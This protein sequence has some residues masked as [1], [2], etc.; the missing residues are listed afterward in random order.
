MMRRE[1]P[2]ALDFKP[3]TLAHKQLVDEYMFKYGENSCQHSFA[4]MFCYKGKY[5][6]SVREANGCLFVCREN[7]CCEKY[8]VYLM[9]MGGS[10]LA[11]AI[12]ALLDD[13]HSRGKLVKLETVTG[14]AKS[15]LE[16]YCPGMF[17]ASEQR[18]SAEY[19][20]TAEKL[21]NLPGKEMASKR[22]DV[23]TFW[24]SYSSRAAIKEM[25]AD[26][27]EEV[28]GF[29]INWLKTRMRQEDKVQLKLENDAIMLGLDN[30]SSL[31]LSGILLYVDGVL[32][33]YAYGALLSD[34]CY[35][36]IIEK[37]DRD[38]SDIYRILNMELVRRCCEGLAF[39]NR[40]EDLGVPGL[41]KSKL[42][43][44]PDIL[45]KKYVLKETAR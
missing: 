35:D 31:R 44:K 40:E 20:Y 10:D 9:P 1:N 11:E 2:E 23:N 14:T 15:E 21:S 6:S 13:A 36:V 38:I 45:L 39:V 27:V 5:G 30:F 29:Q 41:R 8:R 25:T 28:R 43:Y 16:K 34:N 3:L 26:L 22:Y 7:L 37:G 12:N 33:G 17:E 42:S 24:R 19:I 32:R 4:A 18:D